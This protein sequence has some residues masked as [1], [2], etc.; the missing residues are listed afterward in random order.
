MQELNPLMGITLSQLALERPVL[1]LISYC[2]FSVAGVN[3][4]SKSNGPTNV[5]KTLYACYTK[6]KVKTLQFSLIL[7][8]NNNFG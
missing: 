1:H 5:S 4:M 6:V 8:I 2:Y 7:N 3:K